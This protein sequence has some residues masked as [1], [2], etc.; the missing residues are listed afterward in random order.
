MCLI[1]FIY[2]VC[3]RWRRVLKE[4]QTLWSSM[5][6]FNQAAPE[7]SPSPSPSTPKPTSFTWRDECIFDML[8]CY[9]SP[10][11]NTVSLKLV[12]FESFGTIKFL[13][14]HCPNLQRLSVT[15]DAHWKSLL[16]RETDTILQVISKCANLRYLSLN[17]VELSVPGMKAL[18]TNT[19]LKELVLEKSCSVVNQRVSLDDILHEIAENQLTTFC[20]DYVEQRRR[21]YGR[22]PFHVQ[23]PQD[24]SGFLNS[25]KNWTNLKTLQLSGVI[26]FTE[27]AFFNLAVAMPNLV[28]LN[29]SGE[30]VK[31]EI[32][33]LITTLFPHLIELQVSG[34]HVNSNGFRALSTISYVT[35]Q[36]FGRCLRLKTLNIRFVLWP[37]GSLFKHS[38]ALCGLIRSLPELQ[39]LRFIDENAKAD[40]H[41]VL[42]QFEDDK[43]F[44]IKGTCETDEF[45]FVVVFYISR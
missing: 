14:E 32:L 41:E 4:Q 31:E 23:P 34:V 42:E 43:Q 38:D 27:E 40:V 18:T 28:N 8:R 44:Q 15:F 45:G 5:N 1:V 30:W 10:C 2:R 11:L 7:T 21:P 13:Q 39:Y 3:H 35:L 17:N 24:I 9:S 16:I 6:F 26:S 29:I 25:R 22:S 36:S 33:Q 12:S 20:L 37:E 19:S